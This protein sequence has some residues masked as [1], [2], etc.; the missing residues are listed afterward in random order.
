[1][2]LLDGGGDYCVFCNIRLRYDCEQIRAAQAA[3]KRARGDAYLQKALALLASCAL[4]DLF[5]LDPRRH[6][7]LWFIGRVD[8]YQ[9]ADRDYQHFADLPSS[10]PLLGARPSVYL[11][12]LPDRYIRRLPLYRSRIGKIGLIFCRAC[13]VRQKFFLI[14]EKISENLL[15]NSD[16]YSII[17][18]V[19]N[20]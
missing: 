1:M 18:S 6:R 8:G 17:M 16:L 20:G 19:S 12:A 7:F 10:R 14:D 3:P 13:V 11:L 4:P 5:Y 2:W 15:T 9:S